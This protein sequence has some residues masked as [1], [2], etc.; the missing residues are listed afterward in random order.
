MLRTSHHVIR[1]WAILFDLFGLIFPKSPGVFKEQETE[2]TAGNVKAE[3]I[4]LNRHGSCES[5][6]G[7][8]CSKNI[9]PKL[10]SDLESSKIPKKDPLSTSYNNGPH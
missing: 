1:T 7:S 3:S 6:P 5:G 10:G 4:N 2:E 8:Y 9:H